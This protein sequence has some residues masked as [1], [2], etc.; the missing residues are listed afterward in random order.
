[1]NLQLQKATAVPDV[2][3]S[4]NYDKYGSYGTNYLGGGI[5]FN[6]PFFNRNQGGIKQARIAI[7]QSNSSTILIT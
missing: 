4:L 6:L 1:M 2:S 7:D 3:L 5:E